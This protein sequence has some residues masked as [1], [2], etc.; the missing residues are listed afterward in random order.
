MIE[1]TQ[2]PKSITIQI[3]NKDEA[4]RIYQELLFK[5]KVILDI[6]HA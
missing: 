5:G 4:A 1:V 3:D 2:R 6:E